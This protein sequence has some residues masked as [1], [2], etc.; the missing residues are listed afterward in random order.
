[1]WVLSLNLKLTLT[2]YHE[3]DPYS[4]P[5]TMTLTLTLIMSM[6]TT[7]NLIV[8]LTLQVHVAHVDPRPWS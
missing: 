4:L 8:N 2:F 3:I 1:M 7:S 6:S 5:P